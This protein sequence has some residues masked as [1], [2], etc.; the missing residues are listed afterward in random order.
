MS[1]GRAKILLAVFIF[2]ILAIILRLSYWQVIQGEKLIAEAESQYLME[3]QMP[4]SRGLIYASDGFPIVSRRYVYLVYADP[5]NIDKTP[6]EASDK[7]SKIVGQDPKEAEKIKMDLKKKLESKNL[8]WVPL[9]KNVSG[10]EKEKIE[11]LKIKG[12][13][14][15]QEEIRDYPESSMSAQLLG[16]VG[17]D[18]TGQN[19]GYYGV[20]GFY[21]RELS[22]EPGMLR[23]EKDAQ[24]IPIPIGQK[25]ERE[26]VP[27]RNLTLFLNRGVQFM[28]EGKLKEGMTKYGAVAGSVVIMDP[29]SGAIIASVSYPNYDPANYSQ[30]DKSLFP[31]PVVA[32]TFEPGSIFKIL[33]ASAAINEKA[34]GL[35]DQCDKCSG[36]RTIGGYTIRTWNDKYY[37]GSTVT[38]IIQHSDNVGMVSVAERLGKEKLYEYLGR[39]GIGR[40]T[41]VDLEEESIAPLR[42]LNQWGQID[43]ATVSFGQGVAV[44]PM[45]M[46]VAVSAIANGGKVLEPH[47]V[48]K[49][50]ASDRE[51]EV[52]PK[53]IGRVLSETTTKIMTEIMVNAVE[54]GEAKW[55]KPKGYRIAGKT[56]TAQIPIAGHYD[57]EK[58]IASFVG[59]APADQPRFVMLVT[60][61]EPTSSPWGS[62]T[63]A[64]LWFDIA[65]E[66][67]KLWGISPS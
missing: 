6:D 18:S 8:A 35:D 42:P 9:F 41:G 32:R 12:L 10:E 38:E 43:L 27:G 37:P 19:R 56:G 28:A 39:F 29:Y 34:I 2:L 16:F 20:E 57:N 65:K 33:V 23:L 3:R 7:L 36:P 1:G 51:I 22:G 26:G 30:Q 64:P 14:F 24:G 13:G 59:F 44:T 11:G 62:E 15:E 5:K 31:N 67:F 47:V 55:A 52:K 63:A 48:K 61:Q 4:A 21:D 25:V 54:K 40:P 53:V 46:V 49:I 17:K 60:L 66:I 58:T 45:Q 50:T